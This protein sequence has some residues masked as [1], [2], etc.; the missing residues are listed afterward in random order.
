MSKHLKRGYVITIRERSTILDIPGLHAVRYWRWEVRYVGS[1]VAS[2]TTRTHR[3]AKR[4]AKRA[5]R[6]YW[7]LYHV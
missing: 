2:G 1:V 5:A 7:R 6:L 4:T 3:S